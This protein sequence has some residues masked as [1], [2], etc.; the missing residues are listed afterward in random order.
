MTNTKSKSF[1]PEELNRLPF[2]CLDALRAAEEGREIQI[3]GLHLADIG[4]G[5]IIHAI[6]V[7]RYADGLFVEWE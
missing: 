6:K 3:A 4:T 2:V 7:A 5:E 1:T